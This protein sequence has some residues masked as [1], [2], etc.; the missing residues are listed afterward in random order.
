[1]PEGFTSAGFK[2]HF[3]TKNGKFATADPTTYTIGSKD[4]LPISTG[5]ACGPANNVL[6]KDDIMNAYATAYTTPCGEKVLYFA[7]E[8]NANTGDGNLGFWFLQDETVECSSEK[9]ALAFKGDHHE[10]GLLVVSAFTKGRRHEHD[11]GL[12]V[13]GWRHHR[14]TGRNGRRRQVSRVVHARFGGL[15]ALSVV[16]NF[17]RFPRLRIPRS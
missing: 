6:S 3:Q 5:W 9:G 2:V 8:Q 1:L 11:Q 12:Q 14:R 4:T 13:E 17:D 7:L 10:G 15:P 16:D